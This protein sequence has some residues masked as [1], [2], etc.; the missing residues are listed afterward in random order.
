MNGRI[1]NERLNRR[2]G[3]KRSDG[4]EFRLIEVVG[5]MMGMIINGRG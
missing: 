5:V 2:I 3:K 1:Y 4:G